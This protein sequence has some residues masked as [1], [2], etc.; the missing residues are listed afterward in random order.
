MCSYSD[1]ITMNCTY[2][3]VFLYFLTGISGIQL[4]FYVSRIIDC[5]KWRCKQWLY[6]IG[7]NTLVILAL[8]FLSFKFTSLAIVI[9]YNMEL[10]HIAEHPVIDCDLRY[11]ETWWILYSIV[12]IVVPLILLNGWQRLSLWL[13][14][15]VAK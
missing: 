15:L 12:G 4:T 3:M 14:N 7:N 8:H 6:Y 2:N 9:L 1:G 13:R 10:I 5:S 11:H